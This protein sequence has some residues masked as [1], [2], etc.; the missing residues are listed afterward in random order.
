MSSGETAFDMELL[1]RFDF[2]ILIGQIS[3]RQAAE[4]YNYYHGYELQGSKER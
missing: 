3:Y 2:N 4:I 1:N